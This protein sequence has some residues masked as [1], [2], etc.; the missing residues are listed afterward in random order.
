MSV[1]V[2]KTV[3]ELALENPA[4]T[5]VFGAVRRL[6]YAEDIAGGEPQEATGQEIF[7]S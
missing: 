5:R 4:A 1:F 2:E 3:R 6:R 7:L